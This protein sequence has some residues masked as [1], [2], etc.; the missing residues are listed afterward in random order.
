MTTNIF[1]AAVRC[2]V[3]TSE[4]NID[5]SAYPAGLYIVK[6]GDASKKIVK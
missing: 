1:D 2:V 4:K 5:L 3:A 6:A